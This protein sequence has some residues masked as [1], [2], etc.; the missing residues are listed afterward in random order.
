V[1]L[2][3]TLHAMMYHLAI[4]RW[5]FGPPMKGRIDDLI[6]LKVGVFLRGIGAAVT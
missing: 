4:R 2:V 3:Q 1:E 5:V 6:R